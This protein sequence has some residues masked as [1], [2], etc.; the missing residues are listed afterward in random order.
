MAGSRRFSLLLCAALALLWCTRLKAQVDRPPGLL[1]D[2]VDISGDFH[3]YRNT[4][5]LAD[6]LA[7][8]DPA[9]GVGAIA[10]TRNQLYPRI[11]FNNMENVLQPFAGVTFPE[12]EYAVN[13]SLPFS[14]QFVSPRAVRIRIRTGPEVRP[15]QP[16]P[17][18]VRE[19]P[20][21][22][23]WRMARI[24]GGY[25]YTSVAGS[26][27]ILEDPWHIEFRDAQGRLL[28]KTDHASDNAAQLDPVLP[29]SF[30]R[31]AS[32]YSR[33]IAAVFSLAPG[34]KLFGG[35]ESFTRLDKRGQ[36][37][38]LWANDANGVETGRMYKPIPFFMSNRGYGMF[39]H[40]SAPTTFDFG[41]T[42][43]NTNALLLGDDELD[44]FVFLGTPKEILNEYTTLTGKP[45][46]PPLW[47]FGLWMSR[48]TYYSEDETRAVAAKLRGNRIPSDVIHLDTGWFETDWRCDYQF[49]KTRFKDPVKMIADLPLAASLLRPQ[50]LAVSGNPGQGSGGQG[51]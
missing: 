32:D 34:E 43:G 51:R 1:S 37:L 40:T 8:F 15:D 17:M 33:S 47:S 9:S 36:K 41:A 20:R 50:E 46:M 23:S 12:G 39:V 22:D 26:V 2:L 24:A 45:P 6:K 30:I 19:P 38:V 18:L 35:G 44:L 10:W 29:F 4:Y 5:F 27:T 21:D 48:I 42:Y 3:E 49:S 14:I 7:Q 31:R 16:S 11:A 13:P 28:T 25:R